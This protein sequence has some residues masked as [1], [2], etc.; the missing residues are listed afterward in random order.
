MN[1]SAS[2]T[3]ST[4]TDISGPIEI[5]PFEGLRLGYEV[6]MVIRSVRF[7]P[8]TVALLLL[9]IA[10]GCAPLEK[11]VDLTYARAVNATGGSGAL[12]AAQPIMKQS[13]PLL[14]SGRQVIG[15]GEGSDLVTK[16]SPANWLLSALVQELSAA[17]YKVETGPNLPAG[18]PKGVTASILTLSANQSSKMVTVLTVTEVR[19]EIKL[20]KNGQ[21]VKT[22]TASARNQEEGV[23]RSSEPIRWAL[24]SAPAS[25][26]GTRSRHCRQPT[27]TPLGGQT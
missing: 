24:R 15:A 6:I 22:L 23:D 1:R 14:P 20:W 5:E 10:A 25:F 16:D 12:F 3:R 26:A 13:L 17:G 11:R 9:F 19:L 27:V 2:C 4:L 18:V 8:H 7:I 21:L